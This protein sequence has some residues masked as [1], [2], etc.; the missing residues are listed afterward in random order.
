M[1]KMS[2]TYDNATNKKSYVD[3]QAELDKPFFNKSSRVEPCGE[4]SGTQTVADFST[5]EHQ[6]LTDEI[7]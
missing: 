7:Q 2:K 4:S 1:K 6:T 3:F 5:T